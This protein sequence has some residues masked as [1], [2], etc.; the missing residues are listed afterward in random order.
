M[1]RISTIISFTDYSE[2][3]ELNTSAQSS[4]PGR[5][6]LHII[7]VGKE[8][9]CF[10]DNVTNDQ[11]N[12]HVIKPD[13]NILPIK[14]I[15]VAGIEYTR[16]LGEEIFLCNQEGNS[17]M[18][19]RLDKGFNITGTYAFS[20]NNLVIGPIPIMF[21]SRP[22][23]VW[24]E[25]FDKSTIWMSVLEQDE[26]G[27]P[28]VIKE[29][30]SVIY[31]MEILYWDK[32]RYYI[33]YV[34]GDDLSMGLVS[35]S[36]SGIT[37]KEIPEVINAFGIQLLKGEENLF[38]TWSTRNSSDQSSTFNISKIDQDIV[39]REK[40]HSL[41]QLEGKESIFAT[42]GFMMGNDCII[43]IVISNS[44]NMH[45]SYFNE[46]EYTHFLIDVDLNEFS[47]Y[48]LGRVIPIGIP[49]HEGCFLNNRFLLIHGTTDPRLT[50]FEIQTIYDES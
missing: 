44:S 35:V 8:I 10:T 27:K 31:E 47:A 33:S 40:R 9:I 11:T 29:L 2:L 21:D 23:L 50:I 39:K 18:I 5:Y 30:D 41:I 45:R 4:I 15:P 22:A 1:N 43:S 37:A 20:R 26:Y 32:D 12:I 19:S 14:N 28:R 24:T 25:G 36:T 3:P 6:P 49:F 46:S 42:K 16:L 48:L 34:K 13:G 38:I 17:K 7:K